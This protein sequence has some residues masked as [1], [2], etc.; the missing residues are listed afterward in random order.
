MDKRVFTIL[1][2]MDD[3]MIDL[4]GCWVPEIN[5]RYGTTVNQDEIYDWNISQFFPIFENDFWNRMK[6]KSG[7]IKYIKALKNDGHKVY[8]CT[9]SNYKTIKNKMDA[10]LFKFF[11][12]ISWNDVIVTTHKQIINADYLIDDG[13]HNLVGGKYKGIL[14]DAPHNR[15]FNEKDHN[16]IR[17]ESWKEIYDF[18]SDMAG[19]EVCV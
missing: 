9:N 14:M 13:V 10:V 4:L 19:Q 12:Y 8:V 18:I 5:K 6:P 16:I 15:N 17:F 7:A 11:D 3:T 2:D 1:V